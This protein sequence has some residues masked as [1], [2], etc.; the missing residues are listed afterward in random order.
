MRR[1]GPP[2]LRRG[3]GTTVTC[4]AREAGTKRGGITNCSV[5]M[6]DCQDSS[7]WESLSPQ[8]S[9]RKTGVKGEACTNWALVV[10]IGGKAIVRWVDGHPG[11]HQCTLGSPNSCQTHTVKLP[12]KSG[13]SLCLMTILWLKGTK[14]LK[15]LALAKVVNDL[16]TTDL[17]DTGHL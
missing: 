9:G 14:M 5:A 10:V 3:P 6:T 15:A 16:W 12:G 8:R 11:T 2:T 13:Y 17:K 4:K 1:M 7:K